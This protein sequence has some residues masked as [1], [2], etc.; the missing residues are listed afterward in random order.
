MKPKL[1]LAIAALMLLPSL[2]RAQNI[3][4]SKVRINESG[5]ARAD[6]VVDGTAGGVT[7]APAL[8]SRCGGIIVNSGTGTKAMRCGPSTMTV[9]STVGFLLNAGDALSLGNEGQQLWRCI[10]TTG[11]NTTANVIEAIP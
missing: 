5:V 11:D 4:C 10:K 1:I 7:V 9:T 8:D 3:A 6:I 2:A